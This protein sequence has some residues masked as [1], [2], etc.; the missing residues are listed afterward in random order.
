MPGP[1]FPYTELD[2]AQVIRQCFDESKDRLRVDIGAN[3]TL[4]GDLE[5]AIDHTEDSIALGDGTTLFTSHTVGPSTGLDVY[6]IGG[7]ISVTVNGVLTPT[8][9]NISIPLLGV[10]QS[11]TFSSTTKRFSIKLRDTASLKYSYTLGQSGTNY[12]TVPVGCE[13]TEDNLALAGSLTIYFQT[14]KN[15]QTLEIKSWT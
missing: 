6:V 13:L 5:V 9:T 2:Y 7:S 12:V 3:I 10:E 8:I 15:S 14:N 11:H 4:G 1:F